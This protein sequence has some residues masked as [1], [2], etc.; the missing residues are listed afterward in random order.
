MKKC[1][2]CGA[3][4]PDNAK[5]CGS[6]GAQITIN[7]YC[8]E[9]GEQVAVNAKFCCYCGTKLGGS[10][11]ESPKPGGSGGRAKA[12][13]TPQKYSAKVIVPCYWEYAHDFSEGLAA[14][15]DK[16]DK[17]GFIDTSGELVIPCRW[18]SVEDFHQG[19]ARVMFDDRQCG[20]I[21]RRGMAAFPG[22]W[23]CCG[24]FNSEGLAYVYD[25]DYD[26]DGFIDKSGNLVI[27]T[28]QW[29]D[30][31]SFSEG[32]AAVCDKNGKWGYIDTKG[33][34]VVPCEI[35]MERAPGRFHCSRAL[36][37]N[38]YGQ[39]GFIDK[40][41]NVVIP[42]EWDDA[43]DFND[44]LAKVQNDDGLCG[45]INTSGR[46][47]IPC[48]W[49][50][51][52]VSEFSEGLAWVIGDNDKYGFIDTEGRLVIPY[53]FYDPEEG[54]HDG[55]AAVHDE[56]E[57]VTWV[58]DKKGNKVM[59][60]KWDFDRISEGFAKIYGDNGKYGFIKIISEN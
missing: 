40:T 42:C 50:W 1:S 8:P 52:D 11:Q 17:W 35:D 33:S 43:E 46:L 18:E 58:I 39:K 7:N 51:D 26:Y 25:G 54:F 41:G 28:T 6:C 20:Y 27:P 56:E 22:R 32:L 13:E 60:G 44:G 2:Q 23:G 47:V 4:L 5:F 21:D 38:M 30:E 10:G 3:E 55:L 53:S 49:E 57:D 48:Q 37:E 19:V 9:C 12:E 45:F 36:V 59:K 16:N 31:R 14:V 34:L 29:E 15:K 24:S